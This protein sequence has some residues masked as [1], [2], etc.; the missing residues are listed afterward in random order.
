MLLK[1]KEMYKDTHKE[2]EKHIVQSD[3]S[4]ASYYEI[5]ANKKWGDKENNN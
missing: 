5:I 3:K 1:I 4:R 2:A